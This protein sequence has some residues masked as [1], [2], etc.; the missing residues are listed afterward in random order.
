MM[1]NVINNTT[2][3]ADIAEELEDRK[4]LAKEKTDLEEKKKKNKLI[5]IVYGQQMF[6]GIQ[7]I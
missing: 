1:A 4:E 5:Y 3:I 7:I 6:H 2:E